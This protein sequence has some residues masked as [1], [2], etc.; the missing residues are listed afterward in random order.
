[1]RS[2]LKSIAS[3]LI[4]VLVILCNHSVLAA[5][6]ILAPTGVSKHS[7]FTA[8]TTAPTPTTPGAPPAPPATVGTYIIYGG[9][10]GDSGQCSTNGVT[11]G[12]CDTCKYANIPDGTTGD[13]ALVACNEA[14][15]LP[16][17]LITFQFYSNTASGIGLLTDATGVTPFPANLISSNS[18]STKVTANTLVKL[19][20][21]WDQ[22]V[23][24]LGGTSQFATFPN[25]TLDGFSITMRLGISVTGNSLGVA[26]STPTA[27]TG[28]DDYISISIV[29]QQKFRNALPSYQSLNDGCDGSTN[30]PLCYFDVSSGDS[31]ARLEVVD[32]AAGFPAFSNTTFQAI[33]LYYE[34]GGFA[35]INPK[36]S[37]EHYKR[38]VVSVPTTAGAAGGINFDTRLISD[39]T[40][41]YKYYFKMAAE[42]QAGNVGFWTQASQDSANCRAPKPGQKAY[43]IKNQAG[44]AD[45]QTCHIVKPDEISAILAENLNCFIATAAYGSSMATEVQ[46]FR[47]FRDLF[48]LKKA[49]GRSFVE[50]YYR[51]S[52]K[53]AGFIARHESLRTAT[54]FALW[55]VLGF[56]SLSVKMG[57]LN[58]SLL[59]VSLI[60]LA[61]LFLKIIL[62]KRSL[63]AATPRKRRQR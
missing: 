33:R 59:F 24:A 8:A 57:A 39:L 62:A 14:Q 16:G 61:L 46:T 32:S 18:A 44:I 37:F 36:T 58:A 23:Q 28:S 49:W 27:G 31:S 11:N 30:K 47:N 13:A 1:M 54:R 9:A 50:L 56:A 52:P 26:T 6:Q 7:G 17:T 21:T 63:A 25:A 10:A 29:F 15:V 3:S 20:L 34:R 53:I 45:D 2:R 12:T 19:T 48:L 60:I 35:T 43:G 22:L 42:D 55:P 41:T 5:I 38:I 4:F 51:Y 40:N